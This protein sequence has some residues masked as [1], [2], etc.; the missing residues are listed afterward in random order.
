MAQI[1]RQILTADGATDAVTWTNPNNGTLPVG[2][3]HAFGTFGSGTVTLQVSPDNG[4]TWI[5]ILDEVGNPVAFTANG[6]KNFTIAST[7]NNPI[8]SEITRLRFNLAGSTAPSLTLV[9]ADVR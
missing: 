2:T 7:S 3:C 5:D 9:I 8:A 1:L 6:S 4:S